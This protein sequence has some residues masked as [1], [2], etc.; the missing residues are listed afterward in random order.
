MTAIECIFNEFGSADVNMLKIMTVVLEW[1]DDRS[2]RNQSDDQRCKHVQLAN[3]GL[4]ICEAES[5]LYRKVFCQLLSRMYL[6]DISTESNEMLKN[7]AKNLVPAIPDDELVTI[8]LV[9][10]FLERLDEKLENVTV[11]ANDLSTMK[12]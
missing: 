1:T 11:V 12:I 5:P 8:R 6:D 2:L 7:S 3:Q 10:K 4:E 9:E